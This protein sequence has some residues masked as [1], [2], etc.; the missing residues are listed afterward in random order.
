MS[1][2]TCILLTSQAF[3]LGPNEPYD[4]RWPIRR[5]KL[6]LHSGP[7]GSLTSVLQDLCDLWST[8]IQKYLDIPI[9]DLK[10]SERIKE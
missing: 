6:N 8:A 10:V 3:Y 1:Y 7:G 5:G 2:L 4:L 9:K